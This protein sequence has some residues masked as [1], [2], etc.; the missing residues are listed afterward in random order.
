MLHFVCSGPRG[1]DAAV[2]P[3]HKS[4]EFRH[5]VIPIVISRPKLKHDVPAWPSG[6]LY[7]RFGSRGE[8]VLVF[9]AAPQIEFGCP[10][11]MPEWIPRCEGF[12]FHGKGALKR[13]ANKP[14]NIVEGWFDQR[15]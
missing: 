4:F 15:G 8:S 12:G 11:K 2:E 1:Q 7:K 9:G 10:S 3:R 6:Q 14:S 5:P 13:A